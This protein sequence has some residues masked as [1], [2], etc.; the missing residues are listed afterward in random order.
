MGEHFRPWTY[1]QVC[2]IHVPVCAV[3][4]PTAFNIKERARGVQRAFLPD[5][6]DIPARF[7]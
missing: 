5:Q 4:T 2:E 7:G 3:D 1:I 6:N